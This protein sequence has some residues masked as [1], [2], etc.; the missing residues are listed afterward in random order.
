[1][2]K[3]LF[4]SVV[5][6]AI[7]IFIHQVSMAGYRSAHPYLEGYGS[8]SMG[9]SF[10]SK[11]FIP[12]PPNLTVTIDGTIRNIDPHLN[13]IADPSVD[14]IE[15]QK[16]VP[17][18][19]GWTTYHS[20]NSNQYF[21]DGR[22][23]HYYYGPGTVEEGRYAFRARF[24]Y[25][26]SFGG[27]SNGDWAYAT[28][29]WTS[30]GPIICYSGGAAPGDGCGGTDPSTGG[31]RPN[32]GDEGRAADPVN[33]ALG[34]ESYRPKPD[35][36]VYNPVGPA[37]VFQR[38]YSEQ[39]ILQTES[40]TGL[41]LGWSH[42][43]DVSAAYTTG[44][45]GTV[46][47]RF[48]GG[49]LV[50]LDPVLS[51]G[52]PTGSF[53]HPTGAPFTVVGVPSSTTV[54]EWDSLTIK[55][56]DET[57]WTLS[58]PVGSSLRLSRI[59]VKT[60]QYLD[61]NWSG[62]KLQNIK[63]QDLTTLL[64]LTYDTSGNIAQTSDL[65][66]HSTYYTYD[67][68]GNLASASQLVVTGTPSPSIK[69]SYTY[70]S[71]TASD[72]STFDGILASISVPSPTGTGTST[73][74]ITYD[75]DTSKAQSITD[76][77]GNVE[78]YVYGSGV[79]TVQH[80]DSLGSIVLQYNQKFDSL[81]RNTGITD[82]ASKSTTIEYL[83]S[84]NPYKPTKTT[85]RDG[86]ITYV[87][88]DSYGHPTSITTPRSVTTQFTYDYSNWPTGRLSQIQ[89]ATDTP[90]NFSYFSNGLVD[91]ITVA[92][93]GTSTG[94]VN[95][96]FTY[97]SLGNLLTKTV[98]GNNAVSSATTTYNYT[99]DGAYSQTAQVG[100][101]LTVTD[102]NGKVSRFRYDSQGRTTSFWDALNR[103]T[104]FGY[105]IVGK[106]TQ[107][108]YPATGQTGLGQTTVINTYLWPEGP[109]S[110]TTT[111]DESGTQVKQVSTSYGSEGEILQVLGN[112]EL[113]S[114]VYDALYRIK[115]L[116][117]GNLNSTQYSYDNVGRLS[118]VTYPGGDTEQYTSY[119]GEGN[120]LQRIEPRG[121]IINYTY[122]DP[123]GLLTQVDYP[124][125]PSDD[126]N[127][128]YDS[129]GR[130][131]QVTDG[132]GVYNFTYGRNDESLT[133]T[134]TY[135]GLNPVTL[136]KTYYPDGSRSGL[137]SAVGNFVYN[138]DAG[139]RET[140][141]TNPIG[142]TTQWQYYDDSSISQQ[143]YPNGMTSNYG[144]NALNQLTSLQN[145]NSSSS[146]LSA[147]SSF[148]YD[149]NS[150]LLG[151]AT[152]IP[153]ATSYGGT[154]AYTYN[155]KDELLSASSTRA[156]GF[157]HSFL[158]DNAGNLTTIRGATY[159]YNSKN[160]ITGSG[161]SYDAAGNPI[162]Y[163][164]SSATFDTENRLT[165][166]G[167]YS[168]KYR[169]DNLRAFRQS[170]TG[171]YYLYYCDGVPIFENKSN[172]YL[173]LNT[174]GANGLISRTTATSKVGLTSTTTT[175][176]YLFDERGNTIQ[177]L[178]GSQNVIANYS[179]DAYGITTASSGNSDP[180]FDGFGAQYG[181][182]YESSAGLFCCG[183]RY[184]DPVNARFLTRDPVGYS[185]GINQYSYVGNNPIGRVDPSGTSWTWSDVGQSIR[186]FTGRFDDSVRDHTADMGGL[187]IGLA[188]VA[189]TASDLVGNTISGALMMGTDM[190]RYAGGDPCTP[191]SAAILDGVNIVATGFGAAEFAEVG[192]A[193]AA[194]EVAGTSDA[195]KAAGKVHP[196]TGVPF[197]EAGYPIFEAE[198]DVQIFPTGSRAGDFR[199]A[200]KAA[201]FKNT[202]VGFTWHHHQ[203]YARMQLV[204]KIIHQQTGHVGGMS[205]WGHLVP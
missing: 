135:T 57:V 38:T 197:D 70:G 3:Y 149:G 73:S 5:I 71:T 165:S 40:S 163:N 132:Q 14:D 112:T 12:P 102:A 89:R 139:G 106:P 58:P 46:L 82:A 93:P 181:Y 109:L 121:R 92:Q 79:T 98:P 128:L 100:Q 69:A 41:P 63:N 170:R 68:N 198:K 23:Y 77:N 188:T 161:Y 72:S 104:S 84:G 160:Q 186:T 81:L 175:N 20:T 179:T 130:L 115:T 111:Y 120:L 9:S 32:C 156:G 80:K 59:A 125:T 190:G 67:S 126:V 52:N 201:G 203:D 200:N 10:P 191:L 152:S 137:I 176:F 134:T 7:L 42:N 66:G 35:V 192:G 105:N 33:L 34:F 154:N 180:S 31:A 159:T 155:A 107:A 11:L 87:T 54:G 172:I 85:D 151:N 124:L 8:P 29:I 114:Y 24:N 17:G 202:P 27:L 13:S 101:P 18:D 182:Q 95:I 167:G 205:I 146:V 138:Y 187:G 127:Y 36:V 133:E 123:E 15:V 22:V 26:N 2:T 44:S 166:L 158:A 103:L 43:Y 4:F 51:S 60:G 6:S 148:N 204:N 16:W 86:R 153:S 48:P 162:T 65:Y 90:K 74:V 141:M 91:T 96:S 75:T 143:Q 177:R 144:Y 195:I 19:S 45:W 78:T 199:A 76:A 88:Y 147:M 56:T 108:T 94:T 122:N 142:Q 196:K 173:V 21:G 113:S 30:S 145:L 171:T 49:S 53:T 1:M 61:L 183:Y 55:W 184:Y 150:N 39:S 118:Q 117:D 110:T 168:A 193:R 50:E 25:Y 47:L 189:T 169:F 83:D 116:T 129:Y 157:S 131:Q 97:D 37:A 62:D 194:A 164:G 185:G 140:S 136:T 64:T 178:D 99:T 28:A 174:F 119:D